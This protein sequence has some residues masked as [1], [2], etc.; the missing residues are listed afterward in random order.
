VALSEQ[1]N[2]QEMILF[3]HTC[4]KNRSKTAFHGLYRPHSFFGTALVRI[5]YGF[6][7]LC[8]QCDERWFLGT[9]GVILG[10]G[11]R[12]DAPPIFFLPKE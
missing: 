1:T 4:A 3:H 6:R 8:R 10:M 7:F 11:K 2:V 12:G 5:T 9:I